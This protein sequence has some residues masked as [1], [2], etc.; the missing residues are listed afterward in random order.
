MLFGQTQAT[1]TYAGLAP[2]LVGLYQIN[3]VVPSSVQ[4]NDLVPLSFSWVVCQ[5]SGSVYRSAQ[6]IS[7]QTTKPDR[8]AHEWGSAIPLY[9]LS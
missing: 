9:L 3:V 1:T 8:L 6:L 5:F 7:R 2:N 4:N